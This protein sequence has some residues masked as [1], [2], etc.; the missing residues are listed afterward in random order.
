AGLTVWQDIIPLGT[1]NLPRDEAYL[2]GT[3]AEAIAVIK[4]R[5]NHPCLILLEGGEEAF[6]RT[7]DPKFTNDF[8]L[9]LGDSVQNYLNL[10]YVPDSPLTY[11][12]ARSVGY[13]AKEADHVLAYFYAMGNWLMEDYLKGLDYPI[14]PEFA[15]TSVPSVE[16]LKKFI[17]ENELWPPGL[18]WGHHWADLDRLKMQNFDTFD[19]ERT[20]SLEEFVNA[21]QDAQ[22]IIFQLGVEQFRRA[23]PRVSGVALCHL[24]TYWPDMKWGIIDAYQQPKRS[25]THVQNAYQPLLVTLDYAKRRWQNDEPFTASIWVVNDLYDEYKKCNA[26]IKITDDNGKKLLSKT[27]PIEAIKANSSEKFV[28]LNLNFLKKVEKT[29]HVE[30]GLMD[31]NGKTISQNSYFFLIGDQQ[32]ASDKMKA[33]G[34]AMRARNGKYTYGNYYRFFP[35]VVRK[36]EKD[37]QSGKDAPKADGF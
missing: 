24:I 33:M 12:T 32:K 26:V 23:K 27:Y 35:D 10:P 5:R 8:L 14:Y 13:K 2:Q 21:S 31:D 19:D 4:E 18:S 11:A 34:K 15:I 1:G 20:G 22:G 9:A 16:S 7:T 37:W 29:F 25:F 6:L 28:E 3:I 30:L 36:G 17:P